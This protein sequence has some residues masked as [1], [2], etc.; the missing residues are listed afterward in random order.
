MQQ[1]TCVSFEISAPLISSDLHLGSCSSSMKID[2]PISVLPCKRNHQEARILIVED[3]TINQKLLGSLLD[4]EGILDLE[5]RNV[6]IV[7]QVTLTRLWR[8]VLK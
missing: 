4:Q 7:F 2:L 5:S 1:D 6:L 8:M 3:N